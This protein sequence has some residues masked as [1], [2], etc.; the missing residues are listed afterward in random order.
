MKKAVVAGI[1]LIVVLLGG[2]TVYLL[3]VRPPLELA[4]STAE[5]FRQFFNFTPQITVNETVVVEQ[6]TPIAEL[7]TISR[8]VFVETDWSHTWLHSTKRIVLRGVFEAKAGFDLHQPFT[9]AIRKDPPLVTATMPHAKILSLQLDDYHVVSDES[10][11][12]NRIS[13]E[14]REDAFR[15]LQEEA[16]TKALASGILNESEQTIGQRIRE[17]IGNRGGEVRIETANPA[18]EPAESPGLQR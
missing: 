3:V 1:I 5:G 14:D 15:T 11:W 9:I 6:A 2:V 12:W 4:R 8:K 7:A 13:A 17:I 10:G 16:Y 18:A